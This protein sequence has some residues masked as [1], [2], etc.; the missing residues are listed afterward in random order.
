MFNLKDDEI[1]YVK[2]EGIEYIQF[3]KLLKYGIKHAYTLKNDGIDFSFTSNLNKSSYEKLCKAL[4]IDPMLV[5]QPSA[6]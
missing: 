6:S 2:K 1:I 3:K 4:E 5:V